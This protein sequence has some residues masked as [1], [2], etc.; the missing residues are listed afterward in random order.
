MLKFTHAVQASLVQQLRL[1]SL[2]GPV[3]WIWVFSHANRSGKSFSAQNRTTAGLSILA[4]HVPAIGVGYRYYS[5]RQEGRS[6]A[7][8]HSQRRQILTFLHYTIL[9]CIFFG[10]SSILC[11]SLWLKHYIEKRH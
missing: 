9:G 2:L 5:D 1:V 4:S 8:K 7:G 11:T 10:A 3:F 6:C